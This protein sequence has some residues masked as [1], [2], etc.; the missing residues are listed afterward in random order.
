M[1][2]APARR[3]KD[4]V[5]K[6]KRVAETKGSTPRKRWSMRSNRRPR[7]QDQQAEPR[8]RVM[9]PQARSV[10]RV[11]VI[12][13]ERRNVSAGGP[14]G[15]ALRLVF[16]KTPRAIAERARED[17]DLLCQTTERSASLSKVKRP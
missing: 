1:M 15:K 4:A 16:R 3:D 11:L 7:R 12:S 5:F 14:H 10:V 13:N 2:S 17:A 9:K 8:S 6:H